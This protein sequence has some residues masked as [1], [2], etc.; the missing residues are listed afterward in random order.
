MEGAGNAVVSALT[1]GF[2]T[3]ASDALAGIAGIVPVMLP[4]AGAIIVLGI[5]IKSAKKVAK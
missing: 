2:G 1:S 3:V 4:I 5:V